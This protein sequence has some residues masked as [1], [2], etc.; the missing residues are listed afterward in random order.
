MKETSVRLVAFLLCLVIAG[1]WLAVP[2]AV[3]APPDR[4]C[5]AGITGHVHC[6]RDDHVDFDTCQAIG[7]L[8]RQ[9]GIDT[10]FFARLIWQESRFDPRAVSPANALGIAQFIPS[11]AKLRGLS[12]PFNPALALEYSAAYLADLAARFGLAGL[13]PVAAHGGEARAAGFLKGRGLARETRAYVPIVTGLSAE[14]WRD[15]APQTHDFSLEGANA[16]MPACLALAATR[17]LTP[18]ARAPAT[19]GTVSPWGVQVTWGKTREAAVAAFDRKA[20]ACPA[21]TGAG[22]PDYV[23]ET[24]RVPGRRSLI[25][26][27]FGR[28]TRRDADLLCRDLR[29]AGCICAVYR[30]P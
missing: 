6:I 15:A 14:T 29:R 5:S 30:N 21:L 20:N 18:P 12:D 10:G 19:G 3:A 22:A 9:A 1:L 23:A 16:F 7:H 11:T 27:R 25:A 24:S 17:K 26:V 13:A 2:R 28:D 8:S 4:S